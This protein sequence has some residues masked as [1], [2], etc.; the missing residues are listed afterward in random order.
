[1]LNIRFVH[2]GEEKATFIFGKDY[3]GWKVE[4]LRDE[5]YGFIPF[6]NLF[7]EAFFTFY[8]G[9]KFRKPDFYERTQFCNIRWYRVLKKLKKDGWIKVYRVNNKMV[10]EIPVCL[11][12]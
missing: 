9:P 1:M 6:Q 5:N 7:I 4:I 11:E 2:V 10:Y 12:E 3:S 8:H